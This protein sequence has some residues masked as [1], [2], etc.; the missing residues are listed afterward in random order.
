[1]LLSLLFLVW[2]LNYQ[3][4]FAHQVKGEDCPL[5]FSSEVEPALTGELDQV[6]PSLLHVGLYLFAL[7]TLDYSEA[8]V[9]LLVYSCFI[10]I[11]QPMVFLSI[12]ATR[13]TIVPYEAAVV[14]IKPQQ[15]QLLV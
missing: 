3:T 4:A 8:P 7:W 1:L 9:L 14:K 6:P 2:Y 10:G 15:N 11:A 13:A 5:R 12:Q